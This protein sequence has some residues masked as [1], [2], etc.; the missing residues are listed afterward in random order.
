MITLRRFLINGKDLSWLN[1]N[2]DHNA[3]EHK[4]MGAC[5]YCFRKKTV[6]CWN[7]TDPTMRSLSRY[8]RSDQR[9]VNERQSVF[10]K[11]N[12]RKMARKI[13]WNSN[14]NTLSTPAKFLPKCWAL[15]TTRNSST[16]TML[17]YSTAD[18]NRTECRRM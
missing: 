15:S 13:S 9:Q 17:R 8:P 4:P 7:G 11:Q 12:T 3:L 5:R 6:I 2:W 16:R 14:R 10:L 18:C 1:S